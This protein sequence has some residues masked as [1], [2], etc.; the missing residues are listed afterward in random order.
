[1]RI[2]SRTLAILAAACVVAGGVFALAESSFGQALFP[3]RPAGGAGLERR[4]PTTA[5]SEAAGTAPTSNGGTGFR[6]HEH[7][8]G[9][10]PSLFGA[11]E[12]LQNLV[13]ISIIV[14]GVSLVQRIWRGR[15]PNGQPTPTASL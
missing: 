6:G 10:S 15:R 5:A 8:G 2:L 13:L 4:P 12:V 3:A 14:A 9:R 7:E 11:V 1:M